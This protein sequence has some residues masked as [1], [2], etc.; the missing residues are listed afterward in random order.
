MFDN[1]DMGAA[2]VMGIAV[3]MILAYFLFRLI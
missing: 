3:G 1:F 2:L